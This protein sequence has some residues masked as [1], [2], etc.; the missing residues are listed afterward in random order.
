MANW[1]DKTWLITGASSGIGKVVAQT[2]LQCGGRVIATA[3]NSAALVDVVSSAKGRAI[4][5]A[6]DVTK[7]DQVTEA[8]RQAR[9]LGTIDVLFN[10]AG[11]GFMGGI[12]ESADDEIEAQFAVNFLGALR[13]IRAIL[14][15]MRERGSGFIVNVSSIAGVFG[16]AGVGFYSASKFALEG[17]SESLAAEVKPFGI[18][19][20]IVEPGAFRTAFFGRSLGVTRHPHPAYSQL[21]AERVKRAKRDGTQAGDPVRGVAAIIAAMESA[22]PPSRL[23]L[24]RSAFDLVKN[25]LETR[26]GEL[27]NWRESALSADFT[28]Q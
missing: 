26:L 27:E 8:I 3:R 24:G 15:E 11:Y 21:A 13:V 9:N 14:P 20:M 2:I 10:N 4:G 25:V 5:V 12:E 7:A 1:C 17:L 16:T 23:V 22:A 6:L 19:V 18:H 28:D